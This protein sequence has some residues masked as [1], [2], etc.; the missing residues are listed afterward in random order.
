MKKKFIYGLLIGAL[1]VGFTSSMVSCKDYDDEKI[2]NLEGIMGDNFDALFKKM[3][4]QKDSLEKQIKDLGKLQKQCQDSCAAFRAYINKQLNLYVLQEDF[5]KTL[6]DTLG[7][8]YTK[9]EIDSKFDAV[10]DKFKQYYTKED[11]DVLRAS[12]RDSIY[13]YANKEYIM[14]TVAGLLNNGVNALTQELD[15][16]IT[17]YNKIH[18]IVDVNILRDTMIQVNA[19]ID[20]VR[21]MAQ[22]AKDLAEKNSVRIDSLG[23]VVTNLNG[24]V[25]KIRSDLDDII[26]KANDA[27]TQAMTNKQSIENLQTLYN[28]LSQTVSDNYAELKDSIAD[29]LKKINDLEDKVDQN[30]A[31][32]QL[33]H[34]QLSVT[35]QGV[36][37]KV[38]VLE[39]QLN[40]LSGKVDKLREDVDRNYE[41]ILALTIKVKDYIESNIT[42]IEING[43]YNP[44]F[45]EFA[46]PF[47][48]RSDLLVVFNGTVSDRGLQ[49]P[50]RNSA[51]AALENEPSMWSIG[52]F[53]DDDLRML[54]VTSISKLKGYLTY[55]ENEDIIATQYKDGD[56]FKVKEGNAGTIY[57]TVNPTDRDFTG[58]QF[59]LI[60]SANVEVPVQLGGLKKSDHVLTFGVTRADGPAN[61]E[62]SSNGFYEAS[63]TVNSDQAQQIGLRYD[64]EKLKNTAADYYENAFKDFNLN[65]LIDAIYNNIHDLLDA[66]A[67]KATWKVED[68]SY[69]TVSQYALGVT[70][71]K[72]LSFAFG[73]VLKEKMG[74]KLPFMGRVQDF[75]DNMLDCLFKGLPELT[76]LDRIEIS[77]I[78]LVKLENGDNALWATFDFHLDGH[79]LKNFGVRTATWEFPYFTIYGDDGNS[80]TI[81]N[82]HPVVTVQFN[83]GETTA[84]ATIT[85]NIQDYIDYTSRFLDTNEPE[86]NLEKQIEKFLEDVN[87]FIHE[88]TDLNFSNMHDNISAQVTSYIDKINKKYSRF[89]DP[90]KYFKPVL[91]VE[92]EKG[93]ARLNWSRKYPTVASGSVMKIIPTTYNAETIAPAFKKFVAVTN[94]WKNGVSAQDMP[95]TADVKACQDVLKAANASAGMNEVIDGGYTELEVN[96]S[97]GYTY[98]LIYS[99]VDYSGKVATR[100]FYVTVK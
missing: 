42:G 9:P 94:V 60:N 91:V 29:H 39:G 12:L 80:V 90:V 72:P 47:D 86:E 96:V 73:G 71:I 92:T 5:F 4:A 24:T 95:L 50:T 15:I 43:T 84:V 74:G 26:P 16:Y 10:Y 70:S 38:D 30:W 35:I 2:T 55:G 28:T 14:N 75:I 66:N 44:M 46:L 63:V 69:S 57:L 34:Q 32:A 93:L 58:T 81:T 3:D 78:E 54:G 67:L 65:A 87:S 8:Y 6:K 7:N 22:S 89:L 83:Q 1:F 48:V 21:A 98:Q 99:A 36:S 20:V 23:T 37:D 77:D 61:D 59:K 33:V 27:Y 19:R 62:Q 53:T 40:T 41:L 56:E 49:F 88:I 13:K 100:K 85:L 17:N 82:T 18:E 64:L 52:Q 76:I 31:A 68:K 11:I 25:L 51:Y 97:S 45:G 79:Y